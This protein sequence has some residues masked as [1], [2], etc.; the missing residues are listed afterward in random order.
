M[1]RINRTD[2]GL[3]TQL[4]TF[5]ANMN[6]GIQSQAG[7]SS[8]ELTAVTNGTTSYSNELDNVANTR[9]AA[10]SAVQAKDDTKADT[11]S[12]F[13]V[14]IEKIYATPSIDNA[15]LASL[16]LPPRPGT[17][18]PTM[19]VQVENLRG[20]PNANGTALLRWDRTGN[21]RATL[22]LVEASTAGGAF[23][24]VG[25]TLR[26]KFTDTSAVPGVEKTYRVVAFNSLGRAP[27]SSAVTIYAEGE[28]E[29]TLQLAA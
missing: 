19:P 6:T 29:T 15:T 2:A 14:L 10:R 22:F 20:K 24:L 26:T 4:N 3:L 25:Q 17:S 28:G 7:I 23:V 8:T 1:G 9:A 5:I 27:A 13:V 18:L 16:G 21:S 11:I 12:A